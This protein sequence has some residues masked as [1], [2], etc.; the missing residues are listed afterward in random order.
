MVNTSGPSSGPRATTCELFNCESSSH[1]EKK[2]SQLDWNRRLCT[3]RFALSQGTWRTHLPSSSLLVLLGENAD[4]LRCSSSTARLGWVVLELERNAPKRRRA[5]SHNN[6]NWVIK[7]RK[8]KQEGGKSGD[9]S[10]PK[11]DSAEW[12]GFSTGGS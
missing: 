12:K 11:F 10:C 9:R 7:A 3:L 6:C 4:T 1:E 2:E 8:F 5:A